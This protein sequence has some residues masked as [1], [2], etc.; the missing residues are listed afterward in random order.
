MLRLLGDGGS[1][2]QLRLLETSEPQNFRVSVAL[3]QPLRCLTYPGR[4]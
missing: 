2:N 1:R 4:R 3:V